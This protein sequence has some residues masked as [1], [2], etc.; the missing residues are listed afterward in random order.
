PQFVELWRSGRLP[1]ES[2]VSSRITLDD[3]N[4]AMDNLADGTAVRQL[5]SFENV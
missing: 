5:I 3:I 4:T 1:V 2:L